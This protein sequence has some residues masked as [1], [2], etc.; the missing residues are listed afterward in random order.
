MISFLIIHTER[1]HFTWLR[2]ENILIELDELHSIALFVRIDEC[3]VKLSH[4]R[5]V[6]PVFF[7]I[8]SK[9]IFFILQNLNRTILRYFSD[10]GSNLHVWMYNL[11]RVE[12]RAA[13]HIW[14]V[15]EKEIEL[16]EHTE[17]TGGA[18]SWSVIARYSTQHGSNR[19]TRRLISF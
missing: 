14:I 2:S 18:D 7:R 5:I 3:V 8:I 1:E 10:Y 17:F 13:S 9:I 19:P 16:Y 11:S 4:S 12:T 6:F 15:L